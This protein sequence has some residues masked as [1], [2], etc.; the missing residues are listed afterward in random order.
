MH[1]YIFYR[2]S[3]QSLI[4]IYIEGKASLK[5]IESYFRK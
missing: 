1:Y 3:S 5:Q 2:N 4:L